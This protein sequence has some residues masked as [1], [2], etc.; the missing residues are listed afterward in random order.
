MRTSKQFQQDAD[1]IRLRHMVYYTELISEYHAKAGHY[2]FQGKAEDVPV[3][4]HIANE[5]QQK[6]VGQDVDH[7]YEAV[8]TAD[9]F[10]ELERVIG[11]EIPEHYDPQYVPVYKPNF[12]VYMVVR[13]A[14]FLAVHVHQDFPFARKINKHYYKVEVSNKANK[15]N[16]AHP[17][18]RLFASEAFQK[19][20][21]A[22][23]QK[24]AFFKAREKTHM[25]DATP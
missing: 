16:K 24:E 14:F 11:R 9:F 20:L 15:K 10:K 18:G 21:S 8:S 17:P 25:R 2:P 3:Y 1:I 4:V 22:E 5:R 13:D 19:A 6:Y 23:I 7:E 12:Y